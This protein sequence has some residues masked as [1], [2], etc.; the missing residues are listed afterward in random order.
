[1][2]QAI[3]QRCEHRV[4]PRGATLRDLLCE[5][6]RDHGEKVRKLLFDDRRGLLSYALVAINGTAMRDLATPLHED[7]SIVR[8]R[9][10]SPMM[11]GG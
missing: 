3:G 9:V 11:I 1:M 5:L 2:L 6:E 4:L 7:G 10:M 8:I